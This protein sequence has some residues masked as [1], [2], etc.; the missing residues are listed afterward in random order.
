MSL[1]F[2]DQVAAYFEARPGVWIDG[3]TL[4]QVGGAYAS[5]TRISE[6]R[7]DLGMQIDNRQRRIPQADGS[8][9]IISEYRWVPKA[10]A[11]S[12]TA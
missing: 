12:L 5:R 11:F 8:R 2:R 3:R 9:Y 4:M 6:C 1:G 10:D 7:R